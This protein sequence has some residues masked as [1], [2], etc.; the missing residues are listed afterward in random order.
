MVKMDA[1]VRHDKGTYNLLGYTEDMHPIGAQLCGSKVELAAPSAR[2]VEDLGF[3]IIDINCGCPVDKVTKDG[4]GSALLKDPRKIGDIVASVVASV[5]LPVTVKIR[6]GWDDESINCEEVVKIA[7]E[8]GAKAV[9]VHGRTRE[10]AYRGPAKWDYVARA[11]KAA[12]NIHVIGNGDIFTPESAQRILDE[13]HCDG[14]LLSRG[15][16]GAP[17]LAEDV[18][19]FLTGQESLPR[20]QEFVHAKLLE[21]FSFI[22]TYQEERR[23]LLDIRRVGCWYLKEMPFARATRDQI[24]KAQTLAEVEN[25]LSF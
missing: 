10:Q 3:D 8:A 23:A 6:A 25:I 24:N 18:E 19:R 1:L 13:T 9:F 5:S 7:E 2:I 14:V 17:W 11:K 12:K 15:T 20:P 22:K 21:H 4:S 16:L